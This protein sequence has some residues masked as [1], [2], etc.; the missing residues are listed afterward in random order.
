MRLEARKLSKTYEFKEHFYSKKQ[1]FKLFEG[2]S[3]SLDL[4]QNLLI[5]GQ[6]G[7][8]KSTLAKILC[9][10]EKANSGELFLG[11][12]NLFALSHKEQRLKRVFIQ[13]VFGDAK[14]SLNPY[15]RLS[16]LL[17]SVFANFKLA[18]DE[19]LVNEIF[20]HFSLN[21][22]LLKLKP[23]ALSG[24]EAARFALIRALVLK[25]KFLILD[26]VFA[27]LDLPLAYAILKHLKSLQEKENLSYIFI[28][29]NEE[30]LKEFKPQILSL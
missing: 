19:N 17:E 26:E 9:M 12:E 18:Y 22:E 3:F 13:Y 6:S 11:T 7:S 27:N 5:K 28:S 20:S 16:Y 1:D 30:L 14:L 25:P 4:G 21:K 8:G 23:L 15:K 2:L 29:H 24:G 10:I